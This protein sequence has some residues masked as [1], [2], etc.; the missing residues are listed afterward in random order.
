MEYDYPSF[1]HFDF[2]TCYPED[3]FGTEV[4]ISPDEIGSD[5]LPSDFWALEE[6]PDRVPEV[7]SWLARLNQTDRNRIL[8]D[9]GRG[10]Q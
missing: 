2:S 5:Q 9:L 7:R 1:R 8:E 10:W 3:L 4:S 6:E